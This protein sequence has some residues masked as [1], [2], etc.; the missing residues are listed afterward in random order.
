MS[1]VLTVH[2]VFARYDGVTG[3]GTFGATVCNLGEFDDIQPSVTLSTDGGAT[4]VEAHQIPPMTCSDFS[5]LAID[6]TAF[7]VNGPATIA[8]TV[9]ATP[10]GR[11]DQAISVTDLVDVPGP[12]VQ[13]PIDQLQ[14]YRA[15]VAS[16]QRHQNC[17]GHVPYHPVPDAGEIMLV[18]GRY[19]AIGPAENAD[20]L[21]YYIADN[22]ICTP[23]IEAWMNTTGPNPIAQRVVV[24]ND[25]GGGYTSPFVEMFTV[26]SQLG[27]DQSHPRVGEWWRDAINS[28]CNNA[29]ELTHLILGATPMPSLIEEGL[30]TY[31]ETDARSGSGKPPSAECRENGW[32]GWRFED[33]EGER[34]YE[35][36]LAWSPDVHGIYYYFTGMCFWHYLESEYGEAAVREIVAA[37]ASRRDPGFNGCIGLTGS[38]LFVQDIVTPLLGADISPITEEKFGFGSTYTSC[39]GT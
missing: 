6:L 14:A 16:G 30:A 24:D 8:V 18:A 17:V 5:D 26:D 38:V 32:Y 23:R 11:P 13:A 29:H 3:A 37:T 31:M 4:S 12:T 7:G 9:M 10:E 2:Q 25:F 21:A 20:V 27:W 36:L 34:A 39:E 35:N 19:M 1:T 28:R 15:C 33:G 22:A